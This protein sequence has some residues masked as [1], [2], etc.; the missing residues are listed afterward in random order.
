M[1]S[2]C[3]KKRLHIPL[4][5]LTGDVW[6]RAKQKQFH[7]PRKSLKETHAHA[8]QKKLPSG[9]NAHA[10]MQSR[11]FPTSPHSSQN[12]FR[13]FFV[14]R[15]SLCPVDICHTCQYACRIHTNQISLSANCRNQ[16]KHYKRS[17]PFLLVNPLE[18]AYQFGT[19]ILQHQI[20]N[21]IV[22]K[23]VS[24][25]LVSKC[26]CFVA[27]EWPFYLRVQRRSLC[28]PR[29]KY[30]ACRHDISQRPCRQ[31]RGRQGER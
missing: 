12:G 25:R 26:C 15:T 3:Q 14:V 9:C 17:K 30:K 21:C 8:G 5:N 23:H 1:V 22:S 7:L 18:L 16:L 6:R 19:K 13:K 2:S 31:I 4:S 29:R 11:V 20:A 10:R 24:F 27:T 28:V